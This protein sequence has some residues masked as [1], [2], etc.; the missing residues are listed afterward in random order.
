M[1]LALWVAALTL[2]CAWGQAI[3]GAGLVFVYSIQR[4]GARNALAKTLLLQVRRC[5][6]RAASRVV[7]RGNSSAHHH[8]ALTCALHAGERFHRRHDAAARRPPAVLQRRFADDVQS[9]RE[10]RPGAWRWQA[11]GHEEPSIASKAL[12]EHP[13]GPSHASAAASGTPDVHPPLPSCRLQTLYSVTSL[14][15]SLTGSWLSTEAACTMWLAAAG[16]VCRYPARHVCVTCCVLLELCRCGFP[17]A[18]PGS[19]HLQRQQH[20]PD[21]PQLNRYELRRHPRRRVRR[22]CSATRRTAWTQ[23]WPPGRGRTA[24]R[25]CRFNNFNTWVRSSYVDRALLSAQVAEATTDQ[26]RPGICKRTRKPV[27]ASA[28]ISPLTTPP[29]AC[30]RVCLQAFFSGIFPATPSL[31]NTVGE[32]TGAQ[33]GQAV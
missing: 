31:S 1:S 23:P 24:G 20:L 14:A 12:H 33:V 5:A 21:H 27:A 29:C 8:L 17:Q 25:G 26:Q 18:L 13:M 7:K 11:D 6:V 3:A 16:R 30:T 28:R 15:Q 9:S 4:H 10:T 19:N 2:S 32:P 22:P